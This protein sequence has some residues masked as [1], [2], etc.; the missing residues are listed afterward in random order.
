MKDIRKSRWLI[1]VIAV[2][3][4]ALLLE[5]A[6]RQQ[7]AYYEDLAIR[8]PNLAEQDYAYSPPARLVALVVVGP[9]VLVPSGFSPSGLERPI[10]L[11]MTLTA[12]FVFWSCLMWLSR[13]SET[14][15]PLGDRAIRL[16]VGG[17]LASISAVAAAFS[18]SRLVHDVDS[19][20]WQLFWYFVKHYGFATVLW[21]DLAAVLWFLSIAVML[22]LRVA[23]RLRFSRFQRG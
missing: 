2:C 14:E 13:N 12:V 3:A 4:A 8:F 23:R 22:T 21:M 6:G 9:G 20:S 10:F 15:V 7:R 5:I 18:V 1:P 11:V 19:V 16:T 17:F